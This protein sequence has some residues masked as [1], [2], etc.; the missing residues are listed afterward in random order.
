MVCGCGGVFQFALTSIFLFSFGG[1]A[2]CFDC[3]EELL[4][5][6]ASATLTDTKGKSA[7]EIATTLGF[8]EIGG[9]IHRNGGGDDESGGAAA[10]NEEEEESSKDE[11]VEEVIEL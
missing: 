8:S 11:G 2:G 5:N 3:S 7:K 10:N 4:K 1:C 6:G 9:L